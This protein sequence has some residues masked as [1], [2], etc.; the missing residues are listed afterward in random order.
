MSV[1]A[2]AAMMALLVTKT[3]DWVKSLAPETSGAKML[4]PL[5]MVIAVLF[6][7]AF[8]QAPELAG[9]IE[10]LD[11]LTLADAGPVARVLWG[12][13]IGAGAGTVYDL[14]NRGGGRG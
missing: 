12:A 14:A 10:I 8:G 7:L 13:C 11:G 2:P 1:L 3:T 5:S 6:A 4:V 9:H